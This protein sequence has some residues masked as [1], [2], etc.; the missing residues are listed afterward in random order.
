MLGWLRMNCCSEAH[1][2]VVKQGGTTDTWNN[3]GS[4]RNKCTYLKALIFFVCL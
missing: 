1:T 3:S 4:R 2:L